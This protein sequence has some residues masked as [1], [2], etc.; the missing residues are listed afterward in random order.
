MAA[1]SACRGE[2]VEARQIATDAPIA[3]LTQN[4]SAEAR[5][6]A[7]ADARGAVDLDSDDAARDRALDRAPCRARRSHRLAVLARR[8]RPRRIAARYSGW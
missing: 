6:G 4:G 5:A 2:V 3:T 7:R 8:F 1:W